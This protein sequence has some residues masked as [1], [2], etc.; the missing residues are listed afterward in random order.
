MLSRATTELSKSLRQAGFHL[1]I[2]TAGTVERDVDVDLLS[3]SPKFSSSA[4]DP[5]K[6]PTWH[7]R[8]ESR[9]LPLE[10]MTRLISRAMDYQLKFV[11]DSERDYAELLEFLHVIKADES[12]VWVMPQG[13]TIEAL[14]RAE[15]W[16]KPWCDKQGFHYCERM[17]IR[18]FGNRRGT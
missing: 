10:I 6:H 18:W 2:E 8:H 12:K 16:L 17:Q 11:V 14:N 1:T 5:T 3:I 9:R 13:S 4:P 15:Y 7:E